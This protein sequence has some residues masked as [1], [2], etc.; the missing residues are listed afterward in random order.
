MSGQV[1]IDQKFYDQIRPEI[2]A[3]VAS[4]AREGKIS[5]ETARK[6]AEEFDV[7]KLVVGAACNKANFKVFGCGLGC[8]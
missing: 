7:P 4:Q 2:E 3:A 6:I 5:C 8:F 1:T